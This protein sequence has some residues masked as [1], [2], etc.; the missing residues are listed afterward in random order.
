[1]SNRLGFIMVI[2]IGVCHF[3][4]AFL[5]AIC[6]LMS[7]T[8]D[9]PEIQ[10]S[11]TTLSDAV[12]TVTL[13][14]LLILSWIGCFAFFGKFPWAWFYTWV[15]G[16]IL[17]AIGLYGYWT[18]RGPLA[19]IADGALLHDTS[20]ILAAVAAGGLILLNLPPTRRVFFPD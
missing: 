7:N 8:T 11:F 12:R 10:M 14:S 16:V 5:F 1:M 17:L 20:Y 13:L 6:V 18:D 4:F 9:S 3:A 2:A 15:L 19:V